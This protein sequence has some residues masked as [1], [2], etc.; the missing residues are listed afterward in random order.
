MK[1]LFLLVMALSFAFPAFAVDILE[2]ESTEITC[3]G[4]TAYEDGEP[5]RDYD[6]ITYSLYLEGEPVAIQSGQTACSFVVQPPAVGSYVYRATASSAFFG[7][8][9]LP[10]TDNAVVDVNVKK[11]TNT[12]SN[13]VARRIPA[14]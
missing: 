4:P 14:E 2:G 3:D 8:E 1:R 10:S 12:P 7:T 5:I 13:V 11:Q 6:A 9:S